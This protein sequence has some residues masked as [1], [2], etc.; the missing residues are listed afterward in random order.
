MSK[1]SMRVIEQSMQSHRRPDVLDDEMSGTPFGKLEQE[2][3]AATEIDVWQVVDSPFQQTRID[4]AHIDELAAQIAIDGLNQPI[5]VRKRADGKFELI[6][7]RHRHGA[8]KMLGRERIPA[9]VRAYTDAQAARM[10]TA[11]NSLHRKLADFELY[12]HAS[13]L[14][15]GNFTRTKDELASVLGVGTRQQ[16]YNILAFGAFP[17]GAIAILRDKPDLVG[18]NAAFKVS[19]H[20]E[21]HGELVTTLIGQLASGKLTQAAMLAKLEK[22]DKP[23]EL[24]KKGAERREWKAGE[25]DDAVMLVSSNDGAKFTGKIDHAKLWELVQ[26]N[27]DRLRP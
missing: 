5:V 1:A 4:P 24:A 8:F 15:A 19:K 16:V 18:G 3:K 2:A 10:L 26:E 20:C 7:G 13:M 12:L 23:V 22:A 11:D 25:G 21:K 9:Y 6:A 14:E 27:I 17:P